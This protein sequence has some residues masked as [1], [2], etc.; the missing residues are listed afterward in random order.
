MTSPREDPVVN[1]SVWED[2]K[3]IVSIDE[4]PYRFTIPPELFV[5]RTVQVT[6]K[7]KSGGEA[8]DFWSEVAGVKSESIEVRTVP[9]SYRWSTATARRTTTST[10]RSSK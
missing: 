5:Q 7:T 10:V 4:P 3:A 8:A 1:V 9:S 2:G 6:A